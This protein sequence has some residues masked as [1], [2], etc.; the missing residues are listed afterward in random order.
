[1]SPQAQVPSTTKAIII[2]QHAHAAGTPVYHDAPLVGQPI[3]ALKEGDV[4]VKIT[5]AGFNHRELW[6]RKGQYPNV[7]S[8]STLGADGAGVVVASS[9][10]SDTL[11]NKRVVLVPT[12][13]WESDP[14]GPES[15]RGL[16]I[17]GGGNNPPIGTFTEYVVVERDQ[18]VLTPD[19]LDDVQAASLPVAAVTA[20]RAITVSARVQP[21]DNVLITGIGGGVA[22]LALQ[23]CV[24]LGANV[25]VSSGNDAKVAKAVQ[26]GAKGGVNYRQKDWPVQ[27][28]KLLKANG[29]GLLHSVIDS[30]GGPIT[31]QTSKVLRTG[32]RIVCFGMTVAPQ[33]PFTMR[34]VLK[35]HQLLGS[36]MGS[37]EDF[38]NA[39]NFISERRIVPVISHVLPGLEAAEQGFEL[40]KA[41]E[42]LGKIVIKLDGRP[43]QAKL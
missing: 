38:V 36:T 39:M 25:Y 3:P 21:G 41:G 40:L 13:G 17:L 11:L 31:L 27:L 4:L 23:I 16:G 33:V 1:M 10:A 24:V 30:A 12:R 26:L 18:L 20:W 9:D 43:T 7:V 29:K 28:G 15:P 34:E 32:G 22:L 19:H 6:T 8:G 5:A 42:Q 14:N 37:H 2:K 35:G